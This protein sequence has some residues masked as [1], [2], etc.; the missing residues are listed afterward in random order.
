MEDYS[1]MT[2][3]KLLELEDKMSNTYYRF[4]ENDNYVFSLNDYAEIIRE[5]TLREENK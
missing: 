5:I 4:V 3:D 1:E 2:T